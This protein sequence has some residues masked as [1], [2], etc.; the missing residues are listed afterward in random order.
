MKGY[1]VSRGPERKQSTIDKLCRIF[2]FI[3]LAEGRNQEEEEE[4]E[5]EEEVE[6]E[7][8]EEEGASDVSG[9][10]VE[11]M[12]AAA[13]LCMLWLRFPTDAT[14]ATSKPTVEI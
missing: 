11:Q 4:E 8:E 13:L 12:A 1:S 3:F 6:K 7:E 9:A 10:K 5:E 2:C 14:D